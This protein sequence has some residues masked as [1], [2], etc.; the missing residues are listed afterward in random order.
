MSHVLR[1][2]VEERT[3][4]IDEIPFQK[5]KYRYVRNGSKITIEEIGSDEYVATP[6]AEGNFFEFR[7]YVNDWTAGGAI[8]PFISMNQLVAYLNDV[9][10]P[11]RR[12]L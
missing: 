7:R 12:K 10:L 5:G 6:I 3:F 4:Y 2:N 8:L 11:E 1:E 9:M